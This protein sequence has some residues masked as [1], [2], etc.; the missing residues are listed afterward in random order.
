MITG[1][2]LD[3]I[4]FHELRGWEGFRSADLKIGQDVY[5]R[6]YQNY[7]KHTNNHVLKFHESLVKFLLQLLLFFLYFYEKSVL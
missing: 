1:E 2:K 3:N 4:E 7:H 6:Q 5:K